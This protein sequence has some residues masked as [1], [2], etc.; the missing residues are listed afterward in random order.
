[1]TEQA[2]ETAAPETE[3]TEETTESKETETQEEQR[4]FTQDDLKKIAAK[5]KRE[6]KKSRDSE[7]LEKSGA[8][9]VEELLEAYANLQVV[10]EELKS[11][12]EKEIEERYKGQISEV[13][14]K[15]EEERKL[16][17]RY[18]GAIEAQLEAR[19][20]DLPDHLKELLGRIDDPLERYEWLTANEE[21]IKAPNAR[22]SESPP[23]SE[24]GLTKEEEE[25][26]RADFAAQTRRAF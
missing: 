11:E 2:Q 1:M 9:S 4:T 15:L 7:L 16:S 20:T 13:E 6:G 14:T 23:P 24:G 8:K 25:R 19:T 3:A 18:K 17:E 26:A 5:E 21:H 22:V 10:E 12:A